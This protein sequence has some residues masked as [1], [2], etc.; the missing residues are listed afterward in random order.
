MC[1]Q[2]DIS[3]TGSVLN[4]LF[5]FQTEFEFVATAHLSPTQMAPVVA[6]GS[7][8]T[9]KAVPMRWGLE[10]GW[11][12]TLPSRPIFNA[13]SETVSEKPMF[14]DAFAKRRALAPASA[15][16]EWQGE[17][18]SKTRYRFT[19]TDGEP[20]VF[21][22]LWE[23]RKLDTGDLKLTYTILTC[24]PSADVAEYHDRMPVILSPEHWPVWLAPETPPGD[25]KALLKP[26][27]DGF[28]EAKAS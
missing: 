10:P 26:A 24:T 22:G 18:G 20:M 5:G 7:D 28:L 2:Y 6:L 13:R 25:L 3:E 15:F 9:M 4:S 16:Y 14:R 23:K 8:G 27:E 1:G 12:R 11:M 17:P 21:A 19:R